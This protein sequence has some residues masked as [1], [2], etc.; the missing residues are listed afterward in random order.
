NFESIFCS[1]YTLPHILKLADQFQMERVLKQAEKHL[2]HSTGFDEMKKLLFADKY[3]LTSLRDYC[4]GSFTNLTG[5]A[6]KLKSSPEVANFS[7]GMKAMI[8]QKVADL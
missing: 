3:R 7:D 4:L 5:L 2:K 1:D 6:A 8:L